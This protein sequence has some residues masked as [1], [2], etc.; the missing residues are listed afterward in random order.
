M[1]PSLYAYP[2]KVDQNYSW[3]YVL[4]PPIPLFLRHDPSVQATVPNRLLRH[5]AAHALQSVPIPLH[6][7]F[8]QN[9]EGT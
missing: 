6:P 4:H 1:R 7:F 5:L 8:V 2:I 3:P 9:E